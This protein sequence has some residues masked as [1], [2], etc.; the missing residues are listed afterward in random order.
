VEKMKILLVDDDVNI[1]KIG[2]ATLARLSHEVVTAPSTAIAR[3]YLSEITFDAVITNCTMQR[4]RRAGIKVLE[5]VRGTQPKYCQLVAI[6]SKE[7]FT[8]FQNMGVRFFKKG[9]GLWTAIHTYL[10]ENATEAVLQRQAETL[11]MG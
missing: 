3:K 11:D 10:M 6:S 1:L 5:V 2:M 9:I 7:R 8:L 4:D